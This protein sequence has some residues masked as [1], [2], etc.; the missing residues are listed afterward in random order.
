MALAFVCV[1]ACAW[2]WTG[3]EI[4]EMGCVWDTG[5]EATW[6]WWGGEGE[7]VL[8]EGWGLGDELEI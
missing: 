1:H 7:E 8:G 2:D 6:E 3:I 4:F 5:T